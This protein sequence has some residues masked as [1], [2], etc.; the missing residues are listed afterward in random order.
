MKRIVQIFIYL[1]FQCRYVLLFYIT[2][3]YAVRYIHYNIH[4]CIIIFSLTRT[5]RTREKN[6]I[7]RNKVFF[8]MLFRRLKEFDTNII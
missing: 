4:V 2:L 7:R 3:V 6:F 5:A 1:Y 8:N